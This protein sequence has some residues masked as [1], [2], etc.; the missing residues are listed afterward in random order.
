DYLKKHGIVGMAGID[1]RRL[2][3]R[4]RSH[5]AM[6]GILST[7]ELDD[8]RLVAKAKA[9]PGLVGRDLVREV[10]PKEAVQWSEDLGEWAQMQGQPADPPPERNGNERQ[11]HVVA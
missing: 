9:S 3:R 4:I 11:L 8:E 1:T 7:I 2:V 5:G 6:K 10:T